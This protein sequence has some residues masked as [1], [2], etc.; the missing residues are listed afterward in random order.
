M[1]DLLYDEAWLTKIVS[2]RDKSGEKKKMTSNT[3]MHAM[4]FTVDQQLKITGLG[5]FS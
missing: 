3:A 4:I 1:H 5:I 2:V